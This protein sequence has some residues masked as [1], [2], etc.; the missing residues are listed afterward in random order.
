MN[1]YDD[2]KIMIFGF[3]LPK[4]EYVEV[5]RLAYTYYEQYKNLTI[6]EKTQFIDDLP[7]LNNQVK[8]EI[9]KN[10]LLIPDTKELISAASKHLYSSVEKVTTTLPS[11]T[12]EQM[13][14]KMLEYR[15]NN[16]HKLVEQGILMTMEES[17]S[18][19][20]KTY[21]EIK[22]VQQKIHEI[23]KAKP[24]NMQRHIIGE[25]IT[26]QSYEGKIK[27]ATL[28]IPN[29]QKLM[30]ELTTFSIEELAD[31]YKVT[32]GVIEFKQE[33]YTRQNTEELIAKGKMPKP[34]TTRLWYQSEL[35]DDIIRYLWPK[36]NA[37]L[38][39]E[40]AFH[41]KY[42]REQLSPVFKE[43]EKGT[44]KR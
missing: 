37:H 32:P 43:K 39:K 8:D 6:E 7:S 5:K 16:T 24:L 40:E 25:Y 3:A 27:L 30:Q 42:V 29:D 33:E 22:T 1:N 14:S 36:E 44:K 12:Q 19:N 34:T 10:T 15:A 38:D 20:E 2:K 18:I 26:D 28:L 23:M 21:L 31:K 4:E 35:D 41:I 9:V 11:V 17:N 13:T